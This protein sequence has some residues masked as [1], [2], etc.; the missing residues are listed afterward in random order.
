MIA[1]KGS[2]FSLS[3]GDNAGVA[4]GAE[5]I[6]VHEGEYLDPVLVRCEDGSGACRLTDKK[7]QI[8]RTPW[9]WPGRS[10]PKTVEE[11]AELPQGNGSNVDDKVNRTSLKQAQGRGLVLVRPPNAFAASREKH[12]CCKK[13]VN[14][15]KSK[16]K[17]K[18]KDTHT[19]RTAW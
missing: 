12:E 15:L 7:F 2:E 17:H 5:V 18:L 11:L 19:G 6:N 8:T 14:D 1:T 9:T 10:S 13:W 3:N 4:G 16:A